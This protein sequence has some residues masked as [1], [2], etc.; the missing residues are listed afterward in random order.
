MTDP[1]VGWIEICT[2]PSARVDPVA[3]QLE[4][5]WLTCYLLPEKVLVDRENKFLAEFREMIINDLP[6]DSSEPF[7][8]SI[9]SNTFSD[10][11]QAGDLISCRSQTGIL[12]FANMSPISWYSKKKNT[13]ETSTVGFEF[14]AP[15]I[16]AKKLKGLRC[17]LM[18]MG[19]PLDGISNVYVDKESVVNSSVRPK[20]SLK[21]KQVLSL[22][23]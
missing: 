5:A 12:I 18:M 16:A 23:P 22:M 4:L 14:I 2:V 15:R 13:V 6:S 20:T 1:A 11:N 19:V 9:Q 21:R 10:P 7:G 8:K 17:E 3:S